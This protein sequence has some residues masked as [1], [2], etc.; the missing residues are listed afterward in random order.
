M[1]STVDDVVGDVVITAEDGERDVDVTMMVVEGEV[2]GT[3]DD[4][5]GEVTEMMVVVEGEVVSTTGAVDAEELLEV[6]VLGREVVDEDASELVELR[7]VEEDTRVVGGEV[8]AETGLE[9]VDNS[10]AE[11]KN[12]LVATASDVELVLEVS[13]LLEELNIAEDGRLV[14]EAITEGVDAKITVVGLGIDD[15]EVSAELLENDCELVETGEL[16][17]RML[18]L[19]ETLD[20]IG[21]LDVA[22]TLD[23][24]GVKDGV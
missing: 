19:S 15:V 20:D 18:G 22:T 1:T 6:L 16:E 10:M 5:E 3:R 24:V 17:D 21:V 2:V 11:D 23:E 9:V 14:D 4:V 13:L 12:E 7:A 8:V